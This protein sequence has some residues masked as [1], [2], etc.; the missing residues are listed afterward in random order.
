MTPATTQMAYSMSKTITAAAVLQLAEQGRLGRLSIDTPIAEFLPE[1]PYGKQVTVGQ[2]LTHTGGIPNPLP[3]RWVH[4][5]S[6]HDGFDENAALLAVLRVNPRLSHEPGTKFRYS[7]IGY[8]LL[9]KIVERAAGQPF[10]DFVSTN[11]IDRL[12]IASSELGYRIPPNGAHATGYLEKYSFANLLKFFLFDRALIGQ[13]EGRWLSIR[14]HYPNGP[15]FG[16]LIGTAGAFAR[17]LRDQLQP[18]SVL[19]GNETRQL[20]YTQARTS[21]EPIPMIFGWH[22]GARSGVPFFYKEGGG[23]GFHSMMRLYPKEGAGSVIM[24]N[25]T[26]FNVRRALN[27]FDAQSFGW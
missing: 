8:W 4:L 19:F 20:F 23:G 5:A 21:G 13:Y 27:A 12:G 24:T 9:G 25:A 16:G 14:D 6:T 18:Q 2:L 1:S 11:I 3:L 26:G 7:N 10:A 22:V 17:F 15:A